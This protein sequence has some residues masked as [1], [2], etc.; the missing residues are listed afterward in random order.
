M[1]ADKTGLLVVN[2]HP[3]DTMVWYVEAPRN[4]HRLVAKIPP[5]KDGICGISHVEGFF[6]TQNHDFGFIAKWMG[7][8]RYLFTGL[9][10][11]KVGAIYFSEDGEAELRGLEANFQ[12]CSWCQ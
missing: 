9:P 6:I 7:T 3:T 10:A 11:T 2:C 12:Y 1:G 5:A 8:R 4:E